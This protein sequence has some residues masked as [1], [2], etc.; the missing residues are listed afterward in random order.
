MPEL[1]EVSST[2]RS[3]NISSRTFEKASW[4]LLVNLRDRTRL[5]MMSGALR[6]SSA[7][8]QAQ[9]LEVPNQDARWKEAH[10]EARRLHAIVELL[11]RAAKKDDFNHVRVQLA[12]LSSALQKFR[13]LSS[14]IGKAPSVRGLEDRVIRLNSYLRS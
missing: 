9:I 8:L 14:G 3:C 4:E 7:E 5:D 13:S 12:D 6:R 10:V 11:D 1:D 2:L